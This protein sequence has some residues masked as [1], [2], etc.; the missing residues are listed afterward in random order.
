[1][2]LR[3]LG[4]WDPGTLGPL[5]LGT[6]GPWDSWTSSLLQHLLILPLT[7]SYLLLSLPPTLLLWYGLVR[8]GVSCDIGE[9]DWRWTFDLYID[10]KKLWDGWVEPWDLLLPSTFSS[11][12]L[13]PP[14]SYSSQLLLPPPKPPPNSS[15]L[16][17]KGLRWLISSY[18]KRFQ[19]YSAQKSF[20][21]GGGGW[22]ETSNYSFKLQ[23]QVSY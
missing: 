18:M 9:W 19:C 4:P 12:D 16:L 1:M 6:L 8:G 22:V 13:L 15:Y 2:S 14:P 21:G 23:V 10:L 3:Y 7:S 17:L 11:S 5:D 20:M